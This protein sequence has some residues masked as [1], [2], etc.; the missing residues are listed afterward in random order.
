MPVGEGEKSRFW[1]A[2]IKMLNTP[3]CQRS[4]KR[5]MDFEVTCPLTYQHG[6]H[7]RAVDVLAAMGEA[8]ARGRERVDLVDEDDRGGGALGLTAK[9]RGA[10]SEGGGEGVRPER[11]LGVSASISHDGGGGALGLIQSGKVKMR[12]GGGKGVRTCRRG[13]HP[14]YRHLKSE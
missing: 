4:H 9:K 10:G 12:G 5:D 3:L 2:L 1:A 6:G 7:D 13:A 8:R 14:F 11:A